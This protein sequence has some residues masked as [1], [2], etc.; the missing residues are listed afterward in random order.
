V[1]NNS[2]VTGASWN[3]STVERNR[4]RDLA[5]NESRVNPPQ[6]YKA[7]IAGIQANGTR[8]LYEMKNSSACYALYEDY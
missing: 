3:L 4:Y 8:G 1:I 6:D 2:F 5:W 7:S